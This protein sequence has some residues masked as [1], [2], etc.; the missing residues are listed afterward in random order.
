MLT[1]KSQCIKTDGPT[2]NGSAII[3]MPLPLA[4]T[5]IKQSAPVVKGV[6]AA[7]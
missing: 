1:R 5:A 7:S 4:L 3:G 6:P 2:L